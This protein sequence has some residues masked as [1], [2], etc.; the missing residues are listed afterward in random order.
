MYS[1]LRISAILLAFLCS[2][3][4]V[5][6]HEPPSPFGSY[7]YGIDRNAILKR[8]S[9]SSFAINGIHTGTGPGGSLPLRLEIRDLEKDNTTWTLY[10]L[11]L[12]MLHSKNQTEM[13]SWYSLTGR[14]ELYMYGDCFLNHLPGIHGR[15]YLPFD[16]VQATTGNG[17]NGYCTHVSILFPTWH[18]PY[19]ALYEV[20]S[21][22]R[23]NIEPLLMNT[24]SKSYM[25]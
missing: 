9:P 1:F 21:I 15:P 8:Q 13:L 22:H 12:D 20:E 2:L 24:R 4:R 6:A 16:N 3:D 5:W 18:R 25:V 19:L 14:W 7:E 11:G 10:L 17:D 23:V